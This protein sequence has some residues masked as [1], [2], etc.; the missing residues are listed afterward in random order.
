MV[1]SSALATRIDKEVRYTSARY[2]LQKADSDDLRQDIWC[3]V[4]M[5]ES[6]P[7]MENLKFFTT[8]VVNSIRDWLRG[9]LRRAERAGDASVLDYLPTPQEP[10]LR[11]LEACLLRLTSGQQTV[12][13]LYFGLGC[14][15]I[16]SVNRI[17][18][19]T[20]IPRRRVRHL[21]DT[22]LVALK[23]TCEIAA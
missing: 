14:D 17:S 23:N 22:A 19:I 13:R 8:V 10:F 7:R 2:H 12:V 20:D 5:L 6:D 3:H 16:P 21:L 9:F 18:E 1:D 15:P 11:D 4:L